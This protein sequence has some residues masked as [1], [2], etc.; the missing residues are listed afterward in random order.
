M[1]YRLSGMSGID[2]MK[3]LIGLEPTLRVIFLTADYDPELKPSD[4]KFLV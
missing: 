4:N 1:D 2:A 3:E